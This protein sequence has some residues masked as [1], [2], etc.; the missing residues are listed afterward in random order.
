MAN[1]QTHWRDL[2]FRLSEAVRQFWATREQQ[3][4]KQ[5]AL[6]QKDQGARSA[7]TGGAQMDG[8]IRLL[9]DFILS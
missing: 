5:G 4:R 1:K 9:A 8:F 6:G 2:D 3:A 7:V